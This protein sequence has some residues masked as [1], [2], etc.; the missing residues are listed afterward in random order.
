MTQ[1]KILV[2]RQFFMFL[3]STTRG[4]YCKNVIVCYKTNAF[5]NRRFKTTDHKL[6]CIKLPQICMH[7]ICKYIKK[8]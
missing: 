6:A 1:R 4:G 2:F 5:P 7:K 8:E 3:H